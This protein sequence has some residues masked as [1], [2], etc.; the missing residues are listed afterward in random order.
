MKLLDKDKPQA[1]KRNLRWTDVKNQMQRIEKT[2]P[3]TILW[4]SYTTVRKVMIFFFSS[5]LLSYKHA[6][7]AQPQSFLQDRVIRSRVA[8][9]VET[10]E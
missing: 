2:Q 1:K 6:I 10:M 3:P 9:I 4:C 5:L 7:F 8:V